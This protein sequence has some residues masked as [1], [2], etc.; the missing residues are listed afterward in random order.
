MASES[1]HQPQQQIT[2]AGVREK[3]VTLQEQDRGDPN[4]DIA[5]T[6]HEN[7]IRGIGKE[8]LQS[9]VQEIDKLGG[10]ATI[11]DRALREAA[12]NRIHD[13][14]AFEEFEL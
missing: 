7:A 8:P 13:E 12:V 4:A 11:D 1:D 3:I 10:E 6:P 2:L 5:Y 9:L 14:E